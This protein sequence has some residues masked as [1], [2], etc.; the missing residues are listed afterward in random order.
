MPLGDDARGEQVVLGHRAASEAAVAAAVQPRG[1]DHTCQVAGAEERG[2]QG[3]GASMAPH[4][5]WAAR[6]FRA[7]S[8][9]GDEPPI[10]GQDQLHQLEAAAVASV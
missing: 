4:W 7:R 9:A 10:P 8:A 6:Q 2:R 5:G 3:G 1:D